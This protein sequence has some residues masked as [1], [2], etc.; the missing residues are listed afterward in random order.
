ML[1]KRVL[2][3]LETIHKYILKKLKQ[4]IFLRGVLTAVK[5]QV[6]Y[7]W[8]KSTRVSFVKEAGPNTSGT[9]LCV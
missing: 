9:A 2:L 6:I 5:Y 7:I 8:R 3:I 4:E 1:E